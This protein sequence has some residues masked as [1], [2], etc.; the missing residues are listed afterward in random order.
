MPLP[1]PAIFM[2]LVAALLLALQHVSGV[3]QFPHADVLPHAAHMQARIRMARDV[4]RKGAVAAGRV[5]SRAADVSARVA[6]SIVRRV[7]PAAGFGRAM[8]AGGQSRRDAA[9]EIA[10]R[11]A[12]WR[13]TPSC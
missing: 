2:L 13:I 6:D 9:Q 5:G 3:H 1:S 11:G 12:C 10:V 7:G 8:N 4:A